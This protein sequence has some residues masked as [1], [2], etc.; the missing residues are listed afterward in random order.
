FWIGAVP[1]VLQD[2]TFAEKMLISRIQH[3]RCLVRVSSGC[4]KM[5]ANVIM[6]S[7]PMVKV[8]HALP[9]SRQ[10][11]DEILAFVFQGPIKPTDD[12]IKRTPM[13]VR[14][15]NVKNALEWLKLNHVDYKDLSIS[16]ENLN[17]YPLA[18][19]PVEIQY[20]ISDPNCGN[21]IATAMSVYDNEAE[22]G[23]T[24]GP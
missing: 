15:N 3:N 24:N 16:L 23:T 13:L 14:R 8:Y 7:N 12:D 18:G 1:L 4:A 19:V 2:L 22:E 11:I 21:K 6:F 5:I 20:S 10:D 17:S 9:P